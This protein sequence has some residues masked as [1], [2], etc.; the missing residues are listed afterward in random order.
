MYTTCAVLTQDLHMYC[1]VQAR[2]NLASWG[3]GLGPCIA[4]ITA[5]LKDITNETNHNENQR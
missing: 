5:H 1:T 4:Y 2:L 3:K